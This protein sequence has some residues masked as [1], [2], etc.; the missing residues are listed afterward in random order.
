MSAVRMSLAQVRERVNRLINLGWTL[1]KGTGSTTQKQL[2]LLQMVDLVSSTN[3]ETPV[4]QQALAGESVT[5]TDNPGNVPEYLRSLGIHYNDAF[6]PEARQRLFDY[7]VPLY[8]AGDSES[9]RR[10]RLSVAYKWATE[11]GYPT[12]YS[13]DANFVVSVGERLT[14]RAAELKGGG[15]PDPY[16]ECFQYLDALLAVNPDVENDL[17]GEAGEPPTGPGFITVAS[18]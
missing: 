15:D 12:S 7:I 10:A 5:P 14:A 6:T 18:I 1:P 9:L 11:R 8:F 3:G 13:D 2:C 4:W 16:R 17:D